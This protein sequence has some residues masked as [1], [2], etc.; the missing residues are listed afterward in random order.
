[1]I[2][3]EEARLILSDMA[4]IQGSTKELFPKNHSPESEQQWIDMTAQ[5]WGETKRL[6]LLPNG[7]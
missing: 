1:M 5:V 6:F 7:V 2:F 4:V 3:S